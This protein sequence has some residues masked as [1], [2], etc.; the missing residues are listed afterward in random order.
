MT[1]RV[2][3]VIFLGTG[4]SSSVPNVS[5]LTADPQTCRVC[6]AS[7]TAEGAKNRRRNT[8]CVVEVQCSRARG[9]SEL[10]W[11]VIDCGKNFYEAALAHFP[12]HGIKR[13]D[14]LLLTHAHQDAMGGLDDCRAWTLGGHVQSTIPVYLSRVTYESVPLYMRSS[15]AATGGGDLPSFEWHV[16]DNIEGPFPV[17]SVWNTMVQPLQVVHG[18]YFD[19]AEARPFHCWGFRIAGFSY[20]S[21]ASFISDATMQH[22]HGSDVF[23]L[24][25]LKESTHPSHLSIAQAVA[26]IEGLP[27]APRK[28]YLTG[29]CHLV[30][31]YELQDRLR[32]QRVRGQIHADIE[33]AYD[34]LV[35]H[36]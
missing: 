21:D 36:L 4:T 20:I 28:T 19:Q 8:G 2:T 31:H 25:A 27:Q 24:D 30:D 7:M 33:P 13:I 35:V 32:E 10:R 15:K 17:E 16:V 9:G 26:Y 11:I 5:C 12:Q 18:A 29:F 1:I 6:R 14:A 22:V 3:R 23:V 34:G